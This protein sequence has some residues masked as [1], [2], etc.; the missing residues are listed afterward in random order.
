MVE[1]LGK[2]HSEVDE[3]QYKFHQAAFNQAQYNLTI[4]KG[5]DKE[6]QHTNNK[7]FYLSR[8]NEYHE[9]SRPSKGETKDLLGQLIKRKDELEQQQKEKELA[10]NHLKPQKNSKNKQKQSPSN[11]PRRNRELWKR[12]QPYQNNKRCHQEDIH[13]NHLSLGPIQV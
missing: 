3:N 11:S 4:Y 1:T 8:I 2:L 5:T 9:G 7:G 12:N 10:Q 13:L 6:E